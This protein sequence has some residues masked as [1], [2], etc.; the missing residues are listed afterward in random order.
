MKSENK[1]KEIYLKEILEYF[2]AFPIEDFNKLDFVNKD[3]F[4]K[5]L[6]MYFD[7]DLETWESTKTDSLGKIYSLAES[8]K[9]YTNQ[10]WTDEDGNCYIVFRKENCTTNYLGKSDFDIS[11]LD[12]SEF[13]PDGKFDFIGLSSLETVET[14]QKKIKEI[15]NRFDYEN[16]YV[17]GISW[18]PY[19]H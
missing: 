9:N 19:I 14:L 3:C 2:P 17:Y 18:I 11:D 12:A 7:S 6:N 13:L 4:L 1:N 8:I 16:F 15:H 5:S 10:D